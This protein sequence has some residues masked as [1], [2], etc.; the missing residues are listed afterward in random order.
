MAKKVRTD[1]EIA[2]SFEQD[3]Y[4]IPQSIEYYGTPGFTVEKVQHPDN[5]WSILDR[6]HSNLMPGEEF[7]E[8]M[9]KE[10]REWLQEWVSTWMDE[11]ALYCVRLEP[12]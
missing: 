2:D 9:T 8:N 12:E 5:L 3:E 4:E 10:Q 7:D 1:R 11:I 6:I